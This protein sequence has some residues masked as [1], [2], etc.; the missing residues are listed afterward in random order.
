[1]NHGAITTSITNLYLGGWLN[2]DPSV[3][4]VATV[5]LS[6]DTVYLI[7][8]LDNSPADNPATGGV[9]TLA[10]GVTSSTGSWYLTSSFGCCGGGSIYQGTLD[11]TAGAALIATPAGGT[12]NGVTNDGTILVDG[13]S[14]TL[15]GLGWTN[16][17]TITA[18]NYAT[19]DL[20]DNWSNSA[21]GNITVDGTSTVSLGSPIG[22]PNFSAASGYIWTNSGTLAI[23]A[24]AT[25]N[26]GD[27]FTADNFENNFQSQGVNTADGLA[28]LPSLS[29]CLPY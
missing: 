26:L 11:T 25:I 14:L 9:L 28:V 2:A 27:Y 17:G 20:F 3:S 8:T 4:N 15:Q 24:G 18:S 7:G 19:L 12:L 10:P 21:S 29:F 13:S 5:N 6:S 16:N 23:A 1:V 22:S